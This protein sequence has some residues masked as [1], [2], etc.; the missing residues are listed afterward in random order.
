MPQSLVLK[1]D[2]IIPEQNNLTKRLKF[3]I[4]QQAA[5]KPVQNLFIGTV[6]TF[7]RL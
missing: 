3:F 4:H 5:Q 2:I 1:T 7:S 6:E